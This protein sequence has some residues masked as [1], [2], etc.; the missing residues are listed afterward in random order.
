MVSPGV[1]MLTLEDHGGIFSRSKNSLKSEA[2]KR[3]NQY[4]ES[5]GKIAVPVSLQEHPI[6]ILG[7]WASVDYQFRVVDKSDPSAN[8][9]SLVPGPDIR[10][11]S[12]QETKSDINVD[13]R[14]QQPID[15]YAELTKLD[16]LRKRGII[17]EEEFNQQKRRL[18]QSAK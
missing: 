10:I 7:D 5:K 11:E 15:L 4:A 18:L 17:T 13:E 14:K 6:G 1:Y 3:A 8:G 16:D 2:I 9:T 12:Y